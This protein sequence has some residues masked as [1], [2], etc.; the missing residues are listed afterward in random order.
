L[1]TIKYK[2]PKSFDKPAKNAA[3]AKTDKKPDEPDL[4]LSEMGDDD[5]ED[6]DD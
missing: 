6:S 1:Q 4:A 2:V 5:W 3:T